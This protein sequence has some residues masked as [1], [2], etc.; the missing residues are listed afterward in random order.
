MTIGMTLRTETTY[1]RDV[2][3]QITTKTYKEFDSAG[4][5]TFTWM[6]K[7]ERDAMGFSTRMATYSEGTHNE[8]LS[9]WE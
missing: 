5:V 4:T 3:G 6:E 2:E 8:K 7:M 1:E 9:D